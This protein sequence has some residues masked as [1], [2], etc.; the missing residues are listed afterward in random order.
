MAQLP[1]ATLLNK[2][3]IVGVNHAL[4]LVRNQRFDEAVKMCE[5]ILRV[6][7]NNPGAIAIRAYSNWYLNRDPLVCIAETRRA[8]TFAPKS[9]R[10]LDYL[11]AMLSSIGE[12][13]EA[14]SVFEQALTLQPE[15]TSVLLDYVDTGKFTEET[16]LVRTFYERFKRGEYA[17]A[18]KE[19]AAF[20]L[21]KVYDDLKQP[22]IAIELADVANSLSDLEYRPKE[23]EMRSRDLRRL[24]ELG[25]EGCADSGKRANPPIFIIGMPRSGTTLVETILSRHPDVFAAGE[26]PTIPEA[27]MELGMMMVASGN[28]DSGAHTMLRH[29]SKEQL[30]KQVQRIRKVVERQKG[31][32]LRQRFTDKMPMNAFMLPL[33]SRLYP[34]AHIIHMHRHP[35]DVGLSCYFKRFTKGLDFSF[36]QEWIGH[37]YRHMQQDVELSRGLIANPFLDVSYE[38]LIEDFEPQVRRL[39]KF[40]GLKWNPACLNPEKSDRSTVMTA[41]KWQVRQPIYSSSRA[42]WKPYEPYIGKMIEGFGGMDWIEKDFEAGRAAGRITGE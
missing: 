24:A 12:N 38:N 29:V 1:S 8:L 33:I 31:G 25:F 40:L 22:E 23:V 11:G 27:E 42:K 5:Q 37:Y 30:A 6:E 16:P 13:E 21:S 32:P 10:I 35:L 15:N 4:D 14:R 3:E 19:I 26:M 28:R 41:S 20:A 39:L 36:R 7:P 34:T 9:S 17:N 2:K 18:Q